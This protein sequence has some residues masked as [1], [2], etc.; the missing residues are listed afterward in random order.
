MPGGKGKIRHEDGKAFSKENQPAN[1][2]RKPLLHRQI[3]KAIIEQG[4]EPMSNIDMIEAYQ[5]ILSL[6][7]TK[8]IEIAG[9]AQDITNEYPTGY[10]IIAN[11]LIGPDKHKFIESM[12]RMMFS[13]V[14]FSPPKRP[15]EQDA[16]V[17]EDDMVLYIPHNNRDEVNVKILN[18]KSKSNEQQTD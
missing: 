11:M 14:T 2:G 6:P 13:L 8:V 12:N 4:H 7:L 5:A 3:L 10:R 16:E 1:R 9:N 15:P 18:L 17:I